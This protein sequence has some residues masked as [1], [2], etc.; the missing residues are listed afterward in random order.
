MKRPGLQNK[1]VGVLRIAFLVRKVFGTFEKRAPGPRRAAFYRN[2]KSKKL[3]CAI[4]LLKATRLRSSCWTP[5]CFPWAYS[6]GHADFNN[7]FVF[8]G[9]H[10][11][12]FEART[13]FRHHTLVVSMWSLVSYKSP[14]CKRC[15][16]CFYL[17]VKL[18][19]HFSVAFKPLMKKEYPRNVWFTFKI[20]VRK[21]ELLI[22]LR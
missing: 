7:R 4:M 20:L 1:R 5:F 19:A 12:S 21:F 17:S 9:C 22:E 15:D 3:R 6:S 2:K 10:R 16:F 13:N 8:Q 14:R 11:H 18:H